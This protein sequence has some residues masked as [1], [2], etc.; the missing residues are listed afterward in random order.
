MPGIITLPQVILD[1]EEEDRRQYEALKAPSSIV[2][3][4][5]YMRMIAELPYD[6]DAKP[7]CGS[8][9]ERS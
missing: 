8:K 9:L 6:G 7:G 2:I 1:L 3:R 4:Y 5:G